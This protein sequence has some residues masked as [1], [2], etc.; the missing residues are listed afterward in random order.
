MSS[1]SSLRART[2]EPRVLLAQP[3]ARTFEPSVLLTQPR[4][5]TF[6]P[7][8]LLAQPR[9]RTFE[10]RVLLAQPRAR[11]F[12]PRAWPARPWARPLHETTQVGRA[13]CLTTKLSRLR[14]SPYARKA[15]VLLDLLGARYDLVEVP[16]GQRDQ[17]ASVTG[18][19]VYVPV[20]VDDDGKVVVESRDICDYLLAR[21]RGRLVPSYSTRKIQQGP[22]L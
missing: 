15:R 9:A 4:A 19:Y 8:V 20:L 12:E 11:T 10:P 21:A 2:F 7:R 3:H 16:F 17:L 6:E 1:S 22:R 13:R 14:Y 18:G 5:R